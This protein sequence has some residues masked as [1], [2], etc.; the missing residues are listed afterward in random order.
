MQ[1]HASITIALPQEAVFDFVADPANDR[2]W[3]G[4]LVAS[5]GDVTGVGDQVAQT[6]SYGGRPYTVVLKVAEY[7]RP[8]R[9][10]YRL[11]ESVRVRLAFQLQPDASGTRVTAHLSGTIG[12]PAALLADRIVQQA[13]EQAKADLE[14]L[15]RVLE[16]KG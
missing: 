11:S 7:E 2:S 5:Q 8:H 16:A 12:G 3:R 10:A 1:T 4:S 6:Y 15:K 13:T 9:I 14:R